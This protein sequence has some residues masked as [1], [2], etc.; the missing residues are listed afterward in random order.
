MVIKYS[1]KMSSAKCQ[2][3]SVISDSAAGERTVL[4]HIRKGTFGECPEFQLVLSFSQAGPRRL[5]AESIVKYLAK[6]V[7]K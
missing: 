1:R 7:L 6:V 4:G 2:Q 3:P 5:R